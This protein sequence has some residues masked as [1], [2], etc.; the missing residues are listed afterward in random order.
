VPGPFAILN[1]AQY[2]DFDLFGRVH[3]CFCGEV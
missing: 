2:V 3:G 1:N